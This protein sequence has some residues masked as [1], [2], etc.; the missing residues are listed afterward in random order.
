MKLVSIDELQDGMVLAQDLYASHDSVSPF[1]R[2]GVCL[3]Q[4]II[5]NLTRRGLEKV[6]IRDENDIQQDNLFHHDIEKSPSPIGEDLRDDTLETIEEIFKFV[7]ITD[8]DAHAHTAQLINHLDGIVHQ[9][10]GALLTDSTALVNISD[11]RSYDD[12]TFHHSLSV[13]VL[14][15]SMGQQLGFSE[16]ELNRL[17]LCALM[18]DIG[19]TAIPI[20]IIHKPS[21]LDPL[22]FS[23]IQTHSSA[24]FDY[25][26]DTAIGDEDIWQGVL[27]HHEK[28]DGTGYPHGLRGNE[29]P[30]W[31]RIISVADVY[32]AVTSTRPY[33]APMQPSDAIE[34][35]MGG[36]GSAFDQDVI[37]A[38][39]KKVDMYP[40]G[41]CVELSDGRFGVVLNNENQ[42]RPVVQILPTKEIID[43]YN[44]RRLL[45]VVIKRSVPDSE[46]LITPR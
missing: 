32:D 20:E 5:R 44:D 12:Y 17:G 33:R 35:I 16:E 11:L 21:R 37:F 2:Q 19:K 8:E 46:I 18:H 10:V 22:E 41:T 36:S 3:N 23:I 39:L 24:G 9:L 40:V 43:L 31:S 38:L 4:S 34:L 26:N 30:F 27:Y 25:L 7:A 13:A 14:A 28:I 15:I 1:I 42:M 6:Q 45:S 29:I